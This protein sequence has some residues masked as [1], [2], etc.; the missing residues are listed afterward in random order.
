M[1]RL[2]KHRGRKTD[3]SAQVNETLYGSAAKGR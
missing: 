1:R 3:V 2:P